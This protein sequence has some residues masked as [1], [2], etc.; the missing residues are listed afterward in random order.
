[1]LVATANQT[2]GPYWHLIE[3]PS[4]VRPDPLRR[5]GRKDR[6][7]RQ[8]FIDGARQPGH[9]RRDRDLADQPRG[10]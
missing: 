5:A 7:D 6:A 4:L 2:I 10:V 9:R 1:M 3:D 8:R